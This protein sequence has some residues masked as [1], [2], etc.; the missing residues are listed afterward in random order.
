M[1]GNSMKHIKVFFKKITARESDDYW[2]A[3]SSTPSFS[4]L[5]TINGTAS[6]FSVSV[7]RG[8]VTTTKANPDDEQI[9]MWLSDITDEE[10]LLY[11][12]TFGSVA[13]LRV[14]ADMNMQLVS[15]QDFQNLPADAQATLVQSLYA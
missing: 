11:R 15:E 6:S 1:K 14:D 4:A 5:A 9:T 13:Y 8:G 2:Y 12:D 3:Y 7:K 10:A